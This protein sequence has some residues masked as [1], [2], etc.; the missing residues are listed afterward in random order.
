MNFESVV[1]VVFFSGEEYQNYLDTNFPHYKERLVTIPVSL[2]YKVPVHGV[3]D[4]RNEILKACEEKDKKSMGTWNKEVSGQQSELIIFNLLQQKCSGEPS[5]LVNGFHENHLFKVLPEN[6]K[7]KKGVKLSENDMILFKKATNRNYD[8]LNEEV[9]TCFDF[10]E[11]DV[12]SE[13][14]IIDVLKTIEKY[15]PGK[16]LLSKRNKENYSKLMEDY[17]KGKMKK[18]RFNKNE[19]KDLVL[20]KLLDL[21]LPDSEFDILLFRKVGIIL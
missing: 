16:T 13:K 8:P 18:K 4:K 9:N 1:D 5:L 2:Q 11:G 20:K 3:P 10:V 21:T 15:Q 17:L 12:F 19:M 14:N 7:S 6:H